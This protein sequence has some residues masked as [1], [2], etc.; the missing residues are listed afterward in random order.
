M[1]L[2]FNGPMIL[3]FNG[4]MFL[5]L[6]VHSLVF[7]WFS[8]CLGLWFNFSLFQWFSGSLFE[9][10]SRSIP[11]WFNGSLLFWFS[12]LMFYWSISHWFFGSW[13]KERWCGVKL[14][15]ACVAIIIVNCVQHISGWENMPAC[16]SVIVQQGSISFSPHGTQVGEERLC[17]SQ[18]K[19]KGHSS[20]IN[21]SGDRRLMTSKVY[22]RGEKTLGI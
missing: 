19:A 1:I 3:W 9:W 7:V 21:I 16:R 4:P 17:A 10:L 18:F 5:W 11:L 15:R 2:W 13:L 12:G 22:I 8:C 6:V 20:A 14:T